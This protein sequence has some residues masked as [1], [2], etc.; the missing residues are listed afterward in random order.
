MLRL[1]VLLYSTDL[2][3]SDVVLFFSLLQNRIRFCFEL[4]ILLIM[5]I[6]IQCYL[7][8]KGLVAHGSLLSGLGDLHQIYR[9]KLWIFCTRHYQFIYAL[10]VFGIN[11]LL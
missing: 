2:V 4:F 5:Y 11:L 3:V 1:R 8:F 6:L 9:F 10:L 7:I